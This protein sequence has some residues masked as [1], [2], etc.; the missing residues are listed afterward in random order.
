MMP[1]Y[2]K[3]WSHSNYYFIAISI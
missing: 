2:N 3:L 1:N